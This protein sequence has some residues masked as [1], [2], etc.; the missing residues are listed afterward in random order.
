MKK[1]IKISL[2]EGMNFEADVN[3]Y[4]IQMD[5]HPKFGGQ[6][7]GPTPKPLMLAS[8]G[9]CTGMDVIS[10]L[11]KMNIE[12]DEF[13]IQMETESAEEHPKKY[14]KIHMIYIFKGE[15]IAYEKAKKAVDLSYERYCA[16]NAVYKESVEIT[17]EI[18]INP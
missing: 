13:D 2:K 18:R 9:G 17:T 6:G 1:D 8:L 4:K 15:N 10:I 7:K 5:S 16:V 3:G 12:P 14:T 11:R